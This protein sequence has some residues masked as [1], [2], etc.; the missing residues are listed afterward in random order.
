MSKEANI[1]AQKKMGEIINSYQF[2]KLNEVMAADVKD[3][4][5]AGRPRPRP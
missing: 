4:D 3:H 1:A 5:P 2:D